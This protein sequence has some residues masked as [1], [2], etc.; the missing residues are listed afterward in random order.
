MDSGPQG[1]RSLAPPMPAQRSQDPMATLP[2]RERLAPSSKLQA[3]LHGH[4]WLGLESA[5]STLSQNER[6]VLACWSPES[7]LQMKTISPGARGMVEHERANPSQEAPSSCETAFR[8]QTVRARPSCAHLR[9]PC[10]PE[11]VQSEGLSLGVVAASTRDAREVETPRATA[12]DH[13][14]PELQNGCH[15]HGWLGTMIS[16]LVTQRMLFLTAEGHTTCPLGQ[17]KT[18]HPQL[19]AKRGG[20]KGRGEERRGEE[21]RGGEIRIS[22]LCSR[23]PDEL[24]VFQFWSAAFSVPATESWHLG[25]E[26]ELTQE[27]GDKES[28][29][30]R[31]EDCTDGISRQITPNH[32]PP[33]SMRPALP[34]ESHSVELRYLLSSVCCLLPY[35]DV[36]HTV[37]TGRTGRTTRK[38]NLYSAIQSRAAPLHLHSTPPPPP[39]S[40]SRLTTVHGPRDISLARPSE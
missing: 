4:Q 18:A 10:R 32:A 8:F 27:T 37:S 7:A 22:A 26:T 39:P 28:G 34:N 38:T 40:L 33:W 23:L 3:S 30:L 14:L 25:E 31:T 6:P 1:E 35:N 24:P 19:S 17:R 36:P 12:Q 16:V 29:V 21:R 20:R 2:V 13:L 11:D 5:P 15:G 9:F